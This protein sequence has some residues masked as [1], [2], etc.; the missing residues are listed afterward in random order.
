MTRALST[1]Q[2]FLRFA[3]AI[4]LDIVCGVVC[5]GYFATTVT[6]SDLPIMWYVLLGLSTWVIYLVDHLLDALRVPRRDLSWRHWTVLRH[7]HWFVPCIV[8]LGI[9]LPILALRFLPTPTLWWSGIV[10]TAALS[11]LCWAQRARRHWLPKEVTAATIYVGG[12]WF[13]PLAMG[14]VDRWTVSLLALHWVAALLNLTAFSRFDWGADRAGGRCSVVRDWGDRACDALVVWLGIAA[15]VGTV[16]VVLTAPPNIY[17]AA[18]ALIPLTL[19][20]LLLLRHFHWFAT[21]DRYRLADSL[22]LLLAIPA[23]AG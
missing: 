2:R 17:F 23:V 11:H 18:I 10:V 5:G 7:R 14:R 4:S 22:F 8:T 19:A 15:S 13:V 3:Q 20:P 21:S 1:V 6:G 16:V 9:V 12:I